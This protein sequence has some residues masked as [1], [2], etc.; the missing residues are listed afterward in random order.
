MLT[1]QHPMY[2][3]WGREHRGLY[4]DAYAQSIGPEKHPAAMGSPGRRYWSEIWDVVGPQIELV[5][6]GDQAS[7]T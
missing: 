1:T 7:A 6:R 4:N 5:M 3:F 2:V